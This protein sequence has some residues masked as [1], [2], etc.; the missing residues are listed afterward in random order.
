MAKFSS[1]SARYRATMFSDCFGGFGYVFQWN[2]DHYFSQHDWLS[3]LQSEM[4][5]IPEGDAPAKFFS[6]TLPSCVAHQREMD[7]NTSVV[8]AASVGLTMR[9]RSWDGDG[10]GIV[11]FVGMDQSPVRRPWWRFAQLGKYCHCTAFRTWKEGKVQ[12]QPHQH[13]T[14]LAWTGNALCSDVSLS[15]KVAIVGSLYF[16][17]GVLVAMVDGS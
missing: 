12:P 9:L 14:Q 8:G 2:Y 5:K 3:S 17:G 15:I 13:M 6:G 7:L 11:V 1:H 16:V 10:V 4:L